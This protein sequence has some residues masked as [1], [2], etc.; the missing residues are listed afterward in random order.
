MSGVAAARQLLGAEL[1]LMVLDHFELSRLF[2]LLS[3]VRRQL[4]G[5]FQQVWGRRHLLH[6]PWLD[7]YVHLR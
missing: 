4:D 5:G 2:L 7:V 6:L 1:V 3:D